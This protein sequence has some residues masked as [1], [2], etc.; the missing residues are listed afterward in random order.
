MARLLL[1][2]G[3]NLNLLGSREPDVYGHTTL[4]DIEKRSREQVENA[5]HQLDCYQANGEG[6][7]IQRVQQAAQDG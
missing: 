6:E 5:G 1:L 7:L 2:N 4:Q 3:P